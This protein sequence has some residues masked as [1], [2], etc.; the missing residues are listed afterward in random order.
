MEIDQANRSYPRS[1]MNAYEANNGRRE[2]TSAENDHASEPPRTPSLVATPEVQSPHYPND[3][4]P[5]EESGGVAR[6]ARSP[7]DD[8]LDDH[9][10]DSYMTASP[11]NSRDDATRLAQ[12]QRKRNFTN[13]TKT[14]CLTCRRRK[15][16]CDEAQPECKC[17][18]T[19]YPMALLLK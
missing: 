14:G 1:H 17:I 18:S 5:A 19:S 3:S 8:L 9:A 15:K 7:D 4:Q 11:A 2:W 6:R 10:D 16:K 13:R 12:K